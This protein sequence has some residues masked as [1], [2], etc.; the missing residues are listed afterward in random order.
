MIPA[1]SIRA[2]WR[3]LLAAGAVAAA[4]CATFY[5]GLLLLLFRT[6]PKTL[7]ELLAGFMMGLLVVLIGSLAAPRYPLETAL[8]LFT[9]MTVLAGTLSTFGTF[10]TLTGGTIALAV[11][12]WRFH[13]RHTPDSNSWIGITAFAAFFSFM[14]VGYAR[15]TDRPAR[16]DA[17]PTELIEVLGMNAPRVAA[18]YRYDRGGFIDQECLWRIDARPD[19]VAQIIDG[20]GLHPTQTVP[21]G[22]WRMPPHYWPRAMPARGEAFQSPMFPADGRGRDGS[23][24]FLLHD[25]AKNQ[26]FVWV[27]DNF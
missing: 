2:L 10:G 7:A 27:K 5:F 18:F 19:M 11:I 15:F 20:L 21:P 4:F 25:R 17:L 24:Y 26:A 12:A 13:P 6:F 14:A 3:W 23:H 8:T 1:F 22:F 16:P 9:A